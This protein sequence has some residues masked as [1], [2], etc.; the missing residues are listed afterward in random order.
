VPVEVLSTAAQLYEEPLLKS[1]GT[2]S[3]V[4]KV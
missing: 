3:V 1:L 2:V 4:I